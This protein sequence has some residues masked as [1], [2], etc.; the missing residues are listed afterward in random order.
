MVSAD[1]S[2]KIR[3]LRG[4][5]KY[6]SETALWLFTADFQFAEIYLPFFCLFYHIQIA[7][8]MNKNPKSLLLSRTSRNNFKMHAGAAEREGRRKGQRMSAASKEEEK[9]CFG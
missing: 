2:K 6:S 7:R 4:W 3:F 5:K 8:R 1:S 9:I